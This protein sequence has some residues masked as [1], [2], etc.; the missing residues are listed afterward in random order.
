M[1][2]KNKTII[3]GAG[4]HAKV[5]ID[6]LLSQDLKVGVFIYDQN[7]SLLGKKLL[8]RP[9]NIGLPYI[10]S[11]DDIH[12]AIGSNLV[13]RQ[14][15]DVFNLN[16]SS[17]LSI[18]SS[19][20]VI[21]KFSIFGSGVF[22]AHHSIIGP[23]VIVGDFCIINHS[24]V[25]DHDCKLGKYIHV[26]PAVVIGGGVQVGDYSFIGSNSTIL[27]GIKIGTNVTVGA[28]SVVISD[29][30]S[31]SVVAGVPA[32]LIKKIESIA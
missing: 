11:N 15:V 32:K 27:P 24:A 5:V 20:A 18:K 29:I 7:T 2:S 22:L 16:A 31:N 4:G 21:S 6:T 8:N 9:I 1:Y 19:R 30:E 13:R 28:G 3:F 23:D 26:A 12:I 14:L 10:E 17:Y 25:V